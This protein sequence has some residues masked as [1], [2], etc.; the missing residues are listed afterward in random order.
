MKKKTF[1]VF[2][3]LVCILILNCSAGIATNYLYPLQLEDV[4][5]VLSI[6]SILESGFLQ[7]GVFAI[8]V[9]CLIKCWTKKEKN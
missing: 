3:T 4:N 1:V 9:Y 2:I 7:I 5:W 6:I 8:G